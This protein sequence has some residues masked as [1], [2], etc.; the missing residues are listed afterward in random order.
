MYKRG[1]AK[2]KGQRIPI[3]SNTI[4]EA[5][6]GNKNI[7]CVED[8]IHEIFTVGDKFKVWINRCMFYSAVGQRKDLIHATIN[9]PTLP[10]QPVVNKSLM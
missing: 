9:M 1:F 2:V 8:L 6:L 3:T 10:T 4:V 5:K 7:I